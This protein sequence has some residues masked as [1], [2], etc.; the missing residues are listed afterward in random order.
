MPPGVARLS[1]SLSLTL[2]Q[3]LRRANNHMGEG[4]SVLNQEKLFFLRLSYSA[5]VSARNQCSIITRKAKR[6]FFKCVITSLPP[7][8]L[9]SLWLQVLLTSLFRFSVPTILQL[10]PTDSNFFSLTALLMTLR[11]THP[12]THLLPSLF[13]Y[14]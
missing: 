10:S 7:I 2:W 6:L 13:P 11:S 8:S 9:T 14:R 3:D 5:F 12:L 1:R 4:P